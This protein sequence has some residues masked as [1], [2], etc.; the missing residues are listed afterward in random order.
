MKFRLRWLC[1]FFLWGCNSKPAPQDMVL[2][3]RELNELTTVE[4]TVSKIVKASDDQT[5]YKV[6]DRKILMSCRAAVK[7]GIDLNQLSADAIR[8][9]GNKVS[10]DLPSARILSLSI[11]PDEVRTEYEEVGL[12][13]S[14]FSAAERNSLI[15]Q[16]EAQIRR[17][18]AETNIL[19]DAES[20]A[21]I[22]LGN[23]FRNLGF[24][25]VSI[26]FPSSSRTTPAFQP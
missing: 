3:L 17:Q 10:I 21:G 26:Q 22:A 14:E 11:K 18:V 5:W 19:R 16:G 8:V 4:Y 24:S 20:Q 2:Q 1:I 7:A 6:G 25:E 9:D 12:F 13:R 15:A 23:F